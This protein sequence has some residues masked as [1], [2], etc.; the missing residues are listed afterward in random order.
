[1]RESILHMIYNYRLGNFQDAAMT[2]LDCLLETIATRDEDATI[3]KYLLR[4][5]GPAYTCT[6]YW[7]WIEP[8]IIS[9]VQE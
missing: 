3:L 1:M 7:S 9:M 6:N 8:F 5:Q 2:L 4:I